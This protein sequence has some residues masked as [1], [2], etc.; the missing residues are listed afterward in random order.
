MKRKALLPLLIVAA[1]SSLG[2]PTAS[3]ATAAPASVASFS[4]GGP[5]AMF[6]WCG[7]GC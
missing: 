5:I 7:R 6:V 3:A 2:A 1:L 4:D